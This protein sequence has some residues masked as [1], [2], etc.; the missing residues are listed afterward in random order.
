MIIFPMLAAIIFNVA[1]GGNIKNVNIAV[2]NKETTNC[3]NNM[4]KGCLYNDNENFTLSCEVLNGLRSLEYNLVK[5]IINNCIILA[6]HKF[7]LVYNLDRC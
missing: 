2:Y 1:I 6:T 7:N 4:V 5:L 3:R